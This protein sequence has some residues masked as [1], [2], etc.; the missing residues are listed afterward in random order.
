MSTALRFN[1]DQFDK[2]VSSGIFEETVEDRIELIFGELRQMVHPGPFHEDIIDLLNEWSFANVDIKKIRVRI[3]QTLGI[4]ALDSV[5]R[6]DVA[7]VKQRSYRMNR[8]EIDDVLL[9]I[10]VADTTLAYDRGEK[11]RLYAGAGIKEYWIVNVRMK[12]IE[13][14]RNPGKKDYRKTQAFSISDQVA[15]LA[16]PSASL[17][18]RDIFEG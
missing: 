2:I 12:C 8:P 17:K 3:Q 6:P 11:L 13:V 1:T 15:P 16:V 4:P 7:W 18:V 10:E 9:L 14:F 5:P